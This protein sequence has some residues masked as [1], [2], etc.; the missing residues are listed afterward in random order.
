ME[1][2]NDQKS[3]ETSKDQNRREFEFKHYTYFIILNEQ[4][5]IVKDEY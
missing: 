5:R 2:S 1:T 3:M 4:A